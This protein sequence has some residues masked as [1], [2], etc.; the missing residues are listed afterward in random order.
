[1]MGW[2]IGSSRT[3]TRRRDGERGG[4]CAASAS[5]GA[6]SLGVNPDFESRPAVGACKYGFRSADAD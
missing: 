2:L 4:G 3:H 6:S 1:M 5:R